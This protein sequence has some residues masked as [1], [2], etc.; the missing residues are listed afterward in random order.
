MTEKIEKLLAK[1]FEEPDFSDCFLVDL[2]L[3]PSKK[4]EVFVDCDNGLT[5]DKCRIISRYLESFIDEQNWL[6]EKYTIEVSS[7]GI[8][9][10]LTMHRQYV[11]NKGRSLEIVPVEGKKFEGK[12][13]EVEEDKIV[14]EVKERVEGKKRM[15]L[16]NVEIPFSDIKKAKVKISFK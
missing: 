6:G 10:P 3:S 15:E 4:L 2:Q 7:P 11:K 1:K 13:L 16:K 8:T 12:L 14:M 5:L 9:R